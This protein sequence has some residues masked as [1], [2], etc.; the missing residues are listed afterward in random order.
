M[1]TKISH[2]EIPELN[3][4][5]IEIIKQRDALAKAL[6]KVDYY[7]AINILR[8]QGWLRFEIEEYFFKS[9]GN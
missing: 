5:C 1:N 7:F 4:K 8:K 2:Q 6:F 3:N 9:Y